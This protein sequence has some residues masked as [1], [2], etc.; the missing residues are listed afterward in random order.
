[1]SMTLETRPHGSRQRMS[2]SEQL[3]HCFPAA[4]RLLESG[5]SGQV[6]AGM[7]ADYLALGWLVRDGDVIEVTQ[8]GT[9]VLHRRSGLSVATP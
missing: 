5:G 8:A 4:V 3:A 1:M 6:D 7:L 2:R 9:R